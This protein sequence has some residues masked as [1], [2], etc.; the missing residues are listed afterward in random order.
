MLPNPE[1]TYLATLPAE[2]SAVIRI[3]L[4]AGALGHGYFKAWHEDD[5]D[6][7]L[8]VELK[9]GDEPVTLADRKTNE[10]CVSGLRA[11]FPALAAALPIVY[12]G[13]PSALSS[14]SWSA[15][16]ASSPMSP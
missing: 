12:S 13:W 6:S 7:P 1:P 9:D 10:L 16:S 14:H 4:K 8:A 3:A 11:A 15:A 5:H 2:L